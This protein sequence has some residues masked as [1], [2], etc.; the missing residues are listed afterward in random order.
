MTRTRFLAEDPHLLGT[1]DL[2]IS[3]QQCTLFHTVLFVSTLLSD[4]MATS[5]AA[6]M[7]KTFMDETVCITQ[8]KYIC[9]YISMRMLQ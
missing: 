7:M 4:L 6:R 3:G 2:C 8:A 9:Y 1:Q 5:D